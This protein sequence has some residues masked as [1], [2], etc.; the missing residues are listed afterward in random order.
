MKLW[1]CLTVVVIYEICQ[2]FWVRG[3]NNHNNSS[4]ISQITHLAVLYMFPCVLFPIVSFEI[5]YPDDEKEMWWCYAI[6][7]MVEVA[8]F[9]IEIKRRNGC[10]LQKNKV[11]GKKMD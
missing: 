4:K 1:Y 5:N 3:R 11:Y 7:F 2:I 10:K 8:V 9:F 6:F